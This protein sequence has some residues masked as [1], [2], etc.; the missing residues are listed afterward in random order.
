MT[1]RAI[2][3]GEGSAQAAG[4]TITGELHIDRSV[5]AAY[6]NSGLG[7]YGTLHNQLDNALDDMLDNMG[8]AYEGE[9][10]KVYA[11]AK[12][13]IGDEMVPFAWAKMTR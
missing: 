10:G 6:L 7:D 12:V 9:N 11:V 4:Y 5:E 13:C 8:E 2:T 1:F 3:N